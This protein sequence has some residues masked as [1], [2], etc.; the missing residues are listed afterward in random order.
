MKKSEFQKIALRF[1]NKRCV[2]IGDVMIDEWIWGTVNRISPEAPVPVVEVNK[3]TFSPGGASNVATNLRSMGA[4][5]SILGVTGKDEAGLILAKELKKQKIET[6]GLI[7]VNDRP[8]TQ[9]TRI[10]AHNQQVVRTDFEKQTSL[11]GTFLKSFIARLRKELETSQ[12]VIISDYRKGVVTKEVVE[13]TKTLAR[14]QNIPVIVGPKPPIV[15]FC[16]N[17][18]ALTMNEQEG[19]I[20]IGKHLKSKKNLEDAGK[21]ILALTKSQA[22]L[23]TR[24]ENG[25]AL[26]MQGKETKHLAAHASQVY[27]VSG[28]GDTVLAVFA[29]AHVSGS[30][31]ATAMELANI[32]A[33]VV[34]RK[35]GTATASIGEI[36]ALL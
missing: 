3:R 1:Q 7:A 9:K 16:S 20:V 5:V 29:L 23:I 11:N 18:T 6:R 24:G 2:V 22:L 13:I 36:E 19:S 25:M 15:P 17:V 12:L 30:S 14:D 33:S 31:W 35:L 32:A 8:T 21:D 10:I 28:A 4:S 34:V 26:F 27:D